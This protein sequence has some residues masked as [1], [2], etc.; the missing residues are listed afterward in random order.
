M[1][2]I[3]ASEL[4]YE[5]AASWPVSPGR[6]VLAWRDLAAGWNRR[7]MW[8]ALA[9][10]DIKLRYR[11]SLLGPFWLTLSTAIMVVA[12]GVI[13]PY[14]FHMAARQYVPYLAIG[15][16]V[17]QTLAN[18]TNEGCATFLGEE[19]VIQQ[20]P[21]PFSIHAYR[22]VCRNFLVLLHSL[23]IV[24][25]GMIVLQMP[26]DWQLVMIVPAFLLLAINGVWISVLLGLVSARFRDVPPIV[27]NFMQVLFFLTPVMWPIAALHG[28]SRSIIVLNPFFAAIDI[29][30]SPLLGAA[31]AATSWPIMLVTT[32]LGCGAGFVLFARFRTRVAYWI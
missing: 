24:P 14:L 11:G 28:Y 32:A 29:I 25:L 19:S 16:I 21:V 13:Y 10:Q 23:A 12:M 6:A 4:D 3:A 8:G 27:A 20:V 26:V 17:W 31:P 30:R 18:I 1:A 22:C 7:W 2:F 15:L 5:D 9:L